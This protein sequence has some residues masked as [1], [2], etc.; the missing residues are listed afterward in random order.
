LF[1][2]QHNFGSATMDIIPSPESVKSPP[3]QRDRLPTRRASQNITFER[4]NLKF[5]LTIGIYPDGRV[6]EVFL[7]SEH[8]NSMLDAMAH[9]AAILASLC[10]QFGCPLETI[11]HALKR[12]A[13]GEAQSPIGVALDL[14]IS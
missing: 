7:N 9:D 2:D 6:G 14:V 5:Q 4:A 3:A 8:S 10:L 1:S 13:R 12:D 11:A